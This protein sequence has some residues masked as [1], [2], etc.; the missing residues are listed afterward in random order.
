MRARG[1]AGSVVIAIAFLAAAGGFWGGVVASNGQTGSVAG[2]FARDLQPSGVDMSAV[3]K[4]W[5]VIDERF[6]PASVATST[7]SNDRDQNTERVYGMI[8]GLAGSLDDPYSYFLPPVEQKQFEDDMSGAFEGV[9]MEIAVREQILTVVS[10][11][12]ESPAEKA[13]LKAGDRI[14]KI[15]GEE[16]RGFDITTAVSKIRGEKGSIVTLTV[17]REGWTA[18]Q[19]IP[20]TRDV[21][22]FPILTSELRAD[23]VFVIELA[24][25]TANAPGLFRNA[26]REFVE[27][28]S[29]KLIVDVRGNPGGYLDAAVD[30]ASWFLPA[31]KIVVTEDYAGH[32][33][34]VVHRSR[35]YDVFNENLRMVI[36]VDKGSASAS[37]ILALA[38]RGH[39]KAQLVGTP[40]FGKGSVQEL[41]EITPDTSLKLTVARWIG[42]NDE[43]I[44][45]SGIIPDVEVSVSDEDREAGID[46]QFDKAL[47]LLK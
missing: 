46:P 27:S 9:G 44:P 7:A 39:G 41:I 24:S 38:L 12:K 15:D 25:F 28:G 43:P 47:E 31:G 6:V 34:N 16:T 33:D 2:A 23:G 13:G 1:I 4:A 8:A 5:R 20:V 35:G 3:W 40:T 22:N 19:E 11:L 26:L 10:P 37:E 42:P 45:H 30:M 29:N 21:I 32:Q 17:I 14:L 18:P 36:L